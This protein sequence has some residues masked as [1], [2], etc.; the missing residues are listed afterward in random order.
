MGGR[1]PSPSAPTRPG[2][3]ASPNARQLPPAIPLRASASSII[4]P[5]CFKSRSLTLP[6]SSPSCFSPPILLLPLL[7]GGWGA[8][9]SRVFQG[10]GI[11]ASATTAKPEVSRNRSCRREP[12][13]DRRVLNMEFKGGKKPTPNPSPCTCSP[14]RALHRKGRLRGWA[15]T[16]R[17]CC[18][19]RRK[20]RSGRGDGVWGE[21]G[22]RDPPQPAR[23]RA[24]GRSRVGALRAAQE[25]RSPMSPPWHSTGR[26]CHSATPPRAGGT[27]NST[28]VPLG[29]PSRL[30][31]VRS[32][33][34]ALGEPLAP[35]RTATCQSHF[36]KQTTIRGGTATRGHRPPER[37]PAT[38]PQLWES[39]LSLHPEPAPES[40]SSSRPGSQPK[41]APRV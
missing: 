35:V 2:P 24:Q 39:A 6:C 20:A 13:L 17:G 8:G 21:H 16:A 36:L 32:G 7:R 31:F 14:R 23:R 30:A 18:R 25:S 29:R 40:A 34:G 9:R 5:N 28:P 12:R 22:E 33:A 38:A 11:S 15:G 4:P 27:P 1:F 10:A 41:A 19:Q 26:G 3:P 37:G